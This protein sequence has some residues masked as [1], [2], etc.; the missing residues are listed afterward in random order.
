MRRLP[1][2]ALVSIGFIGLSVSSCQNDP[3]VAPNA[4]ELTVTFNWFKT[5]MCSTQSPEIIV[6]GIPEKTQRLTIRLTDLDVPNYNHG[7]GDIPIKGQTEITIPVGSLKNEYKG[8]CPPEGSHLYQFK[9][10]ALT[11][12]QQAIAVGQNT[13]AFP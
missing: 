12:E 4:T 8:P 5:Q 10:W 9:V 3:K 11:G 1:I 2:A 13:Q 7:G 6:Q